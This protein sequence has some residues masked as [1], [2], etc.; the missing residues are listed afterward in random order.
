MPTELERFR[1]A[2]WQVDAVLSGHRDHFRMEGDCYDPVVV[3]VR[4]LPDPLT[5]RERG[6]VTG[7]LYVRCRKCEAC[8]AHRSRL[9]AARAI[10][11]CRI[12][13]RTWFGTLTVRPERQFYALAAAREAAARNGWNWD[14]LTEEE[15]FRRHHAQ[16]VREIQQALDRLRKRVGGRIRYLLTTEIHHGGGLADGWPHYHLL[17]HERGAKVRHKD[18]SEVWRYGFTKF[19]LVEDSD[20]KPCFYVCKYLSKDARCRVMASRAYGRG[21]LPHVRRPEWSS[22]SATP[23]EATGEQIPEVPL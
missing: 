3:D 9:W 17:V 23:S 21:G 2:R 6:N 13:D 20:K 5:E 16:H 19:K 12:A 8:M 4:G 1:V 22:R 18:L 10:D 14:E 7:S 15:R 11:E